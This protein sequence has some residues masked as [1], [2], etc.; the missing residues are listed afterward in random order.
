MVLLFKL[1]KLVFE[2]F[3]KLSQECT[4]FIHDEKMHN[5][6]TIASMAFIMPSRYFLTHLTPGQLHNST[7][8]RTNAVAFHTLSATTVHAQPNSYMA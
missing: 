7:I 8:G 1:L 6:S 5:A 3:G 4:D 2:N